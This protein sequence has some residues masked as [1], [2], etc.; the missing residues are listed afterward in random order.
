MSDLAIK[1]VVAGVLAAHGIGHTI[2]WMPALGMTRIAGASGDSWLLTGLAGD[3][4]ARL[5][6]AALFVVPTVGFVAAAAGLM[7]GQPWWRP[8]AAGSAAISLVAIGLYPHALPTGPLAG[9]VTVD[10]ATLVL[11]LLAGWPS[12]AT[13]GA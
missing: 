8:V 1:V 5:A 12:V 13:V 6:A 11:L 7:L 3:Q 9:A 10:V 4:A 2:G